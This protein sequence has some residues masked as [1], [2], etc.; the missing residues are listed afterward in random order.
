MDF[1]Y[2]LLE[3]G[4]D[5]VLSSLESLTLASAVGPSIAGAAPNVVN[6][7][8]RHLKY[9]LLHLCS[10]V[11]S[12]KSGFAK[13]TGNYSSQILRRRMRGRM[14]PGTSGASTSSRR[15]SVL[16]KIA[17]SNLLRTKRPSLRAS[18][19]GEISWNTLVWRTLS[20]PCSRAY[21]NGEFACGLR[22]TRLR[23]RRA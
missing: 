12:S 4:L 17:L 3:N 21:A 9:A 7:Q 10:G 20:R 23:R 5:F 18:V 14:N 1:H 16:K 15:R 6:G 22:W 2:S 13:R 8:K 11:A 19:N